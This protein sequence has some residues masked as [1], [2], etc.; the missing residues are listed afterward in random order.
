MQYLFIPKDH[1]YN[2]TIVEGALRRRW[3]Q[4]ASFRPWQLQAVSESCRCRSGMLL[5]TVVWAVSLS[6]WISQVEPKVWLLL[7]SEAAKV[8]LAWL[9]ML[10]FKR[11]SHCLVSW[12]SQ[13]LLSCCLQQAWTESTHQP[14]RLCYVVSALVAPGPE[15]LTDWAHKSCY[16]ICRFLRIVMTF[17]DICDHSSILL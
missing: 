1:I 5:T 11:I 6:V 7:A 2:K 10:S 14:E 8:H 17:G 16:H 4:L 9:L 15:V 3:L 13:V 12:I